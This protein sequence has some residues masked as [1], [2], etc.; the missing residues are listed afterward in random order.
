MSQRA[1]VRGTTGSFDPYR[2]VLHQVA[3]DRRA[4]V[5]EPEQLHHESLRDDV[6]RSQEALRLPAVVALDVVAEDARDLDVVERD[7]VQRERA[8][9]HVLE[10]QLDLLAGVRRQ[11]DVLLHP[12]RLLATARAGVAVAQVLSVRIVRRRV[13]RGER[14]RRRLAEIDR[15]REAAIEAV[16]AIGPPHRGAR[17]R[18]GRQDLRSHASGEGDRDV[19]A[20]Q[21]DVARGVLVHGGGELPARRHA[22]LIGRGRRGLRR[23]ARGIARRRVRRRRADERVRGDEVRVQIVEA[24]LTARLQDGIEVRRRIDAVV[25]EGVDERVAAGVLPQEVEED[26]CVPVVRLRLLELGPVVELRVREPQEALTVR[27]PEA[28]RLLAELRVALVEPD[29]GPLH[30]TVLDHVTELV[31]EDRVQVRLSGA[32]RERVDVDH[33]ALRAELVDPQR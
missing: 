6:G 14:R 11:I 8:V 31:R 7:A 10:P 28:V 19:R 32:R 21:L 18:I 26:L 29:R 24:L 3:I 4:L 20:R 33:L 9:G 12:L 23:L 17:V 16:G 30:A 27:D 13:L 25:D 2:A 22:I 15:A 5:G 1:Q